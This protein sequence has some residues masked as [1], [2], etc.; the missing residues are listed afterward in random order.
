MVVMSPVFVIPWVVAAPVTPSV[1]PTVA[2][3]VTESE[4]SVARPLVF[5]VL[6][7]VAPVTCKV[8]PTV[9]LFVIEVEFNVARPLVSS[10]PVET[11]SL[12]MVPVFVMPFVVVAPVTLRLPPTLA[13]PLVSSVPVETSSLVM[14]PA[15]VMPF[16]VVEPPTFRLFVT[17]A[18]FNVARPLVLSVLSEVAPVTVSVPPTEAL[19][20]IEA[21]LSVARP[22]VLSVLSVVAPVAERFVNA[23][24]LG[25][26]LPIGV[27]LIEPPVIAAPAIVPLVI[28]VP[29]IV[30]PVIATA[31]AFC[32]AIE[33]KPR[34]E[35]V[36]SE[37][38]SVSTPV[39]EI[40]ASPES[41]TAAAELLALPTMMSPFGTFIE[42]RFTE[43]GGSVIEFVTIRFWNV[44]V[45]VQVIA[46]AVLR[47]S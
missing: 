38:V 44:C 24:L 43:P 34:C 40:D 39:F 14:V 2:L 3:F 31:F 28:D 10:V 8:P 26:M 41:T 1:P 15:F 21:E 20:V 19:F 30:P 46:F 35:R 16:V 32:V 36:A 33:P 12:V 45:P 13:S 5:S 42:P 22:L 6:S 11:S 9:A 4:F 25:V 7:E 47:L 27:L 23:P 29:S 17:E 37:F 18:E